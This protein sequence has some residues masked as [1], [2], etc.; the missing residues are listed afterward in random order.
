MPP[1][2]HPQG[3]VSTRRRAVLHGA[4]G[5][6]ARMAVR[7]RETMLLRRKRHA[8]RDHV[9]RTRLCRSRHLFRPGAGASAGHTGGKRGAI[10]HGVAAG[11]PVRPPGHRR[12]G[13]RKG[14]YLRQLPTQDGRLPGVGRRSHAGR[15]LA[16]LS[17][18]PMSRTTPSRRATW[19]RARVAACTRCCRIRGC[20]GPATRLTS[21]H[22]AY[23]AHTWRI[24]AAHARPAPMAGTSH[25][26]IDHGK[27]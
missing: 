19:P 26:G 25:G 8:N 5:Q 22:G 11:G 16:G 3:N 23:M 1:V 17:E 10:G 20:A 13:Q 2:P 24:R 18:R 6:R 27:P 12:D 7:E 15:E 4:R 21:Q 9:S 14:P